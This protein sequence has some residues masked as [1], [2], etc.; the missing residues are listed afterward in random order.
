MIV[1]PPKETNILRSFVKSKK[2]EIVKNGRV[3][4]IK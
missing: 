4:N 1:F 2:V 3:D